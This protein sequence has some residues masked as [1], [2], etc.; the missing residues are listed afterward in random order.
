VDAGSIDGAKISHV[1]VNDGTVEG[2][3][4]RGD[5]VSV[6]FQPDIDEIQEF[7]DLIRGR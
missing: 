7:I 3:R 2:I 6:Q 5:A 4:W 1:N